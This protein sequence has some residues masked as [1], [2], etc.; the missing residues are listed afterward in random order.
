MEFVD[1]ILN[2]CGSTNVILPRLKNWIAESQSRQPARVERSWIPN[3]HSAKEAEYI[4]FLGLFLP[5]WELWEI[6]DRLRNLCYNQRYE[7]EWNNVQKLLHEVTNLPT[8]EE[9][10]FE[11]MS[12][13]S[14]Y[15]NFLPQCE[16]FLRKYQ[17]SFFNPERDRRKPKRLVRHRGYRDKG[18][19]RPFHQRGRNIG[20]SQ[21]GRDDRYKIRYSNSPFQS[22]DE[23]DWDDKTLPGKEEIL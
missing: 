22:L 7:G 13:D 19:L 20:E 18:S 2:R 5:D 3:C 21:P 10:I 11:I 16:K 4:I 23:R 6:V 14:F 8:F 12:E 9:S 17:Y 1:R 15:G